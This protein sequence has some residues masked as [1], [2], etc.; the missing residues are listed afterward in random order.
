MIVVNDGSGD[1]TLERLRRG[2][3]A[4]AVPGVRPARLPDRST[5][6]AIYRSAAHPNLV[7]VDKENGGKADAWNAGA[8]RRALPLRLRRRRG[9]GLR[10]RGAAEGD[11]ASSSS[12]PA[13]IVGVTSQITTADGARSASL[14]A[15]E[16]QR[17][18]DRRPLMAS[19]S[20]STSCARSSTTG[21]PGRGSAS[22]SAPPAA[23]RSGAATCS[24]RS[25][26]TRARSR[27]RTSS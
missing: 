9:H 17:P 13:R 2:V 23:S 8:Q 22:C 1:G 6:R 27:A 16:G 14:A 19:T 3:R 4:R 25:A 21:S 15:P 26:A 5:V 7:V 11:A 18:I 10:P 24:R 20:T 12:D